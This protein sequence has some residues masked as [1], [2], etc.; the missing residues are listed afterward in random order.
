MNISEA[1]DTFL[2]M[3]RANGRSHNTID[4]Y[5]SI[6]GA[7]IAEMG[8]KAI[9]DVLAVD[10]LEYVAGLAERDTRYEN[11][12]QRPQQRG[13]LS[14]YS[15]QSHIRAIRA[16]WA[17]V[18]L[19]YEIRNPARNLKTRKLPPPEP[20]AV[21]PRDVLR[22]LEACPDT[23][24][25]WRD[26]AIVLFLMDTGARVGGLV[27]VRRRG[28]DL[29]QRRARVLEKGGK[30]RTV[31]FTRYTANMLQR[32]LSEANPN[33]DH[34]FTSLRTGRTLTT[35]GV[36]QILRRL[37]AAAGVTSAHN[38]HAFRD[39]FAVAFI[40]EG[41]DISTL[42][43]LLGHSDVNVTADHYALFTDDELQTLKDEIN[44]LESILRG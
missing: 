39:G 42:A 32:W 31:Y 15:V 23:P 21:K 12:S 2:L 22:M 4:W 18:S 33:S 34:V 17:F 10:V 19:E 9:G 43:R 44:P 8:D 13:G 5:R 40:R 3:L 16:F 35:S 26:R 41:G 29:V 25:G 11:A 30:T 27:S 36:Y 38:P 6:L 37:G 20:K 28:L 24:P 14:A 7:M 1:L